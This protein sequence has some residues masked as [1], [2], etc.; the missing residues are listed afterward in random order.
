MGV[1]YGM[2]IHLIFYLSFSQHIFLQDVLKTPTEYIIFRV[3]FENQGIFL[4]KR[5]ERE[6]G[7]IPVSTKDERKM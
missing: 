1:F 4:L 2:I 3:T 6:R 5:E 7:V